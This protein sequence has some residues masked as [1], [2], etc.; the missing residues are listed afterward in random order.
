MHRLD[1]KLIELSQKL[2]SCDGDEEREIQVQISEREKK[3]MPIY[4]QIAI[5]FADSHDKPQRMLAKGVIRNI[6]PWEQ[7]RRY[8]YSRLNRR[9]AE[10]KAIKKIEEALSLGLND[11][12][13][14]LREDDNLPKPADILENLLN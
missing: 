6:V 13:K 9:L 10:L 14:Q 5:Q 12:L 2:K 8:F 1:Q 7:S 11:K 4:R 3:L